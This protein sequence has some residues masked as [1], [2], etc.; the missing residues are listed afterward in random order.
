MFFLQY[1]FFSIITLTFVFFKFFVEFLQFL[2]E[3]KR[4]RKNATF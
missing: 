1:F 3:F 4:L 2:S